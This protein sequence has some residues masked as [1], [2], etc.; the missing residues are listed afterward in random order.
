MGNFN[1]IQLSGTWDNSDG[2]LVFWLLLVRFE[3][4]D[5]WL[6]DLGFFF[7]PN[8]SLE[9]DLCTLLKAFF[10]FNF[11]SRIGTL[12]KKSEKVGSSSSFLGRLTF[13]V[14]WLDR[15]IGLRQK[16]ASQNL[17]RLNYCLSQAC[18]TCNRTLNPLCA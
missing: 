10:I 2:G 9:S 4:I 18:P 12:L 1:L 6:F 7:D 14:S 11:F 3:S 17:I 13:R 15:Q 16:K 5:S 8:R